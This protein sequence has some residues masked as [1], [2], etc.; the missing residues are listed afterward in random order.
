M[1][2]WTVQTPVMEVP[3]QSRKEKSRKVSAGV[4]LDTWSLEISCVPGSPEGLLH[5]LSRALTTEVLPMLLLST[6]VVSNRFPAPTS[7]F[8]NNCRR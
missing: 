1:T 3:S 5:T 6:R 2:T 4:S 7:K 8:R